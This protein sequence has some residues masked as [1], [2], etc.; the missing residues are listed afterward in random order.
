MD[1]HRFCSTVFLDQFGERLTD[2]KSAMNN[3]CYEFRETLSRGVKTLVLPNKKSTR[4]NLE[5]F[6]DD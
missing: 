3:Q 1:K 2:D 6:S 5:T 4:T